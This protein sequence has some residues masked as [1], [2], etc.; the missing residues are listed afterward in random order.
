MTSTP[1]RPPVAPGW[2]ALLR[3]ALLPDVLR[4]R[5]ETEPDRTAYIFLDESGAETDSLTYRELYRRAHTVAGVLRAHCVPGDRALLIFPQS[6]DFIV[7]YFGCLYARVL[8]VPVQ[9]PRRGQ[10][11][12]STKSI[13]RDCRP[14]A[15]L[16]VAERIEAL[17]PAVDPLCS[18][19][20][21]LAVD[22]LPMGDGGFDAE[23]LTPEALAFL[24]YTSG[25][26]ANP[27]GVMVSHGN[28]AANQ[29]MIRHAFDHDEHSTFVGWTP[30]FHDQ[31]L[32]GNVLQPLYIGATSV[33]MAPATFIRKPLLWLHAIARYRAHTSGGPDFAFA[34][35]VNH[36]AL[37]GVPDIDL[38]SWRVA[39]NGAEPLRA[40]TLARFAETFAPRGFDGR[41]LYPCYGLAEATLLVTGSVPGAGPRTLTI[42]TE[43][44]HA[45]RVVSAGANTASRTL[46]GSGRVLPNEDVAIVDPD[47]GGLCAPDRVGEIWIAG[48]QVAHGYWENPAATAD[49]F[50][51]R[52]PDRPGHRYLRTG[53]LGALVDGELYVTGRRKDMIIVRGRNHYPHDI[54][55]TVHTAHPALRPGCGTAFTVDAPERLIVV[56]EIHRDHL[57][58]ADPAALAAAIRA[59][60]LREHDLALADLVLTLPGEIPKTSSG[61]LMRTAA[62]ARYLGDGFPR[63]R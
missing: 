30:L 19:A 28:L 1:A 34:A 29:E 60:V 25:S 24:Q 53:D 20:R 31:G 33:L 38:S 57:E 3:P 50:G 40:D 61:K 51:A 5:A 10:L 39:Y 37:A 13:V 44:L 62:R 54:E 27:K 6:L 32:I 9:P 12:E 23:P 18:D 55:H 15:A 49:A 8:A 56:Q 43:A 26:T 11:Q 16:T 2:E 48:D 7:A 17:R 46:V 63:S 58:T 47:T 35:C 36:A 42:D 45:G 59:A 41:A 22:A 4:Q 52:C 21:W 14:A